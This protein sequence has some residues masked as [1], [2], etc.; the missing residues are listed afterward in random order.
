MPP[1]APQS[2]VERV[3]RAIYEHAA[4]QPPGQPPWDEAGEEM[5]EWFYG[6]ARAAIGGM[7]HPTPAMKSAGSK[8]AG[9][10]GGYDIA[11]DVWERMIQAALT[12]GRG[13]P[14]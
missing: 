9:C 6:H 12:E 14:R 5:W 3:A 10:P 13:E 2:M 11:H 8:V 1:E 7:R 4:S